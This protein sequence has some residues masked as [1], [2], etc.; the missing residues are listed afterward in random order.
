M[1]WSE[2]SSDLTLWTIPKA[3]AKNSV[4]HQVPLAPWARSILDDT[5]RING[6]DFVFTTNGKAAANNYAKVKRALDA[7]LARPIDPWTFHDLRRSMATTMARLG[8]QLPVVEKVLNHTGSSFSG[9][10]GI[11]Q[12]FNFA[13]E[14]R[15]ALEIWAAHLL[16]CVP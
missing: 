2:L 15:Q 12:K 3:R 6:S 11:Y 8:V 13:D 1:R 9:V 5:P 16:R 4:E 10:A 14:K 7:A